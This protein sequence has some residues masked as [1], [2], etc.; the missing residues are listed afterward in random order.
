MI[1]LSFLIVVLILASSFNNVPQVFETQNKT[2][3]VI[4]IR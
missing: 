4:S 1:D 3:S 2:N